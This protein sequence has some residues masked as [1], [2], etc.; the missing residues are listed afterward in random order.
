MARLANVIATIAL[1]ASS[2]GAQQEPV[3]ASTFDWS[4]TVTPGGTVRLDV[5]QGDI[6]VTASADNHMTVHGE[7]R[8]GG[9]LFQT[10]TEGNNVTV[11]VFQHGRC[12]LDGVHGHFHVGVVVGIH[13]ASAELTVALPPG[14]ILVT[15][16]SDGDTEVRGA[17]AGVTAESGDGD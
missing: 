5:G 15:H 2:V 17:G 7:R 16:T 14:A 8:H 6:R 12:A 11:C 9:L 4:G 1:L 3:D 10:V 13:R